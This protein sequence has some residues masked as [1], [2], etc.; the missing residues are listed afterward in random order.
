MSARLTLLGT[1]A[2]HLGQERLEPPT[3]KLHALLYYLVIR[4]EW[5]RRETLADLFWALDER[6][7]RNNLRVSLTKLKQNPQ[8]AWAELEVELNRVRLMIDSD[9][10]A[11]RV[12][13]QA[14][15]WQEALL[16]YGGPLLDGVSL[17]N[18]PHFDEWLTSERQQLQL[19]WREAAL[20]QAALW[21]QQSRFEDASALMKTLHQT[22][23][24]FEDALVQF[25]RYADKDDNPEPALQYFYTCREQLEQEGLEPSQALL[26]LA[27]RLEAKRQAQ[28]LVPSA[29]KPPASLPTQANSFIGRDTELTDLANHLSQRG[30]HLLTLVGLGGTGKTRLAL[31][32]AEYH[33]ESFADGVYFVPLAP[34]QSAGA[35]VSALLTTL[36]LSLRAGETPEARLLSYLENK[37]ILF[38][39]DNFEHLLDA[40]VLITELLENTREVKLLV[41]SR[42]PLN[43]SW[44]HTFEVLGLRYPK[45]TDAE[46][47]AQYDAVRLFVR[48]ARQIDANFQLKT[49]HHGAVLDVCRQIEGLPLGLELAAGWVQTFS[50]QQIADLLKQD[51]SQVVST[52][53]DIPE[54]HR[55]LAYVFE[56]SWQ[57]LSET[58]QDVLS[59]LS[60]FR[61]GFD[62][63]AV[64]SVAAASFMTL[65]NLRQKSLVRRVSEE[66]FDLHEVIRQGGQKK[67]EAKGETHT[68]TRTAHSRYYLRLV[69]DL[70]EAIRTGQPEATKTVETDLDNVRQA[71]YWAVDSL[72]FVNL[73]LSLL[74][75][76]RF[77][78]YGGRLQEQL[79]L[80]DYAETGLRQSQS[81]SAVL[82]RILGH[83]AWTLGQLGKLQEAID[84][85][86]ESLSIRRADKDTLGIINSLNDLGTFL[87]RR[88][89][90][91]QARKVWE[92]ALA[93]AIKKSDI[94]RELMVLSNL[95]V[96]EEQEGQY[97]R[98]EVHYRQAIKL[99][100]Q[101]GHTARYLGNLNN[102]ATLLLGAQRFSEAEALLQ[103]GLRLAEATNQRGDLPYFLLKLARV[104]DVHKRT[105]D[106]WSLAQQALALALEQHDRPYCA[107][108]YN[109]LGDVSLAEQRVSQ[110][111]SY[112]IEGLKLA[113]ESRYLETVHTLLISVAQA[114]RLMGKD[115]KALDLLTLLSQQPSL[116]ASVRSKTLSLL[117]APRIKDKLST[118]ATPQL[119]WT[120]VDEAVD[121]L[122]SEIS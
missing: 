86:H 67:L 40:T 21:E 88:G 65:V 111:Y 6:R 92:E 103:E 46:N 117:D 77:Y 79:E 82:A 51:L 101:S 1:P 68:T 43:L 102:L 38:V 69:A 66:R 120:S 99:S 62:H 31:Q 28:V 121:S 110:G 4:T 25:L 81:Q 44:E 63:A 76:V 118:P 60:V 57:L 93:L 18:A 17:R 27:E 37:E 24:F 100:E 10:K 89:Q 54:R 32:T 48:T 45:S 59:K 122:L 13:V 50:C 9:V 95:A 98:A 116:V 106:A 23:L 87:R 113:W 94:S 119:S 114:L 109:F 78:L 83:K 73:D 16:T 39:L 49:E 90:F 29:A 55:S 26:N 85:T 42:E 75:L 115:A 64:Q 71:W 8:F 53:R 15:Q 7:A 74:S 36:S 35:V 112:L 96:L 20:A 97:E 5:V 14:E 80:L 12:A 47:F 104:A 70:A 107:K 108:I 58:E 91:V 19:Q 84:G 11:F 34:L 61:G 105:D 33:K 22:D 56:Q 2:I 52:L 72:D 3:T 30:C 41:T